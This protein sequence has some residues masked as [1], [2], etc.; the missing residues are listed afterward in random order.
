[1]ASYTTNYNL[2]KPAPEDFVNVADINTNM[3]IIDEALAEQ[4]VLIN[5]ADMDFGLFTDGTPVLAH[6]TDPVSYTHLDVYKRQDLQQLVYDCA[7]FLWLGGSCYRLCH[8][9]RH[10]DGRNM[11]CKWSCEGV[12]YDPFNKSAYVDCVGDWYCRSCNLQMDTVC[13]RY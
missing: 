10:S 2:K 4:D 3:D 6:N 1:M 12:F 11:D 8:S 7:C 5:S 13:W 9:I